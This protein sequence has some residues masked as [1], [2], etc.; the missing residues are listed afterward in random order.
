MVVGFLRDMS[1]GEGGG[2]EG[3]VRRVDGRGKKGRDVTNV[4]FSHVAS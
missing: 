3:F 1:A 4:L 2:R